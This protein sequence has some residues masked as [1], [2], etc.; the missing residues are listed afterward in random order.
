MLQF[1]SNNWLLSALVR[2]SM[3]DTILMFLTQRCLIRRAGVQ[4]LWLC[5]AAREFSKA[6]WRHM[7]VRRCLAGKLFVRLT[8]A[9]WWKFYHSRRPSLAANCYKRRIVHWWSPPLWPIP[10]ARQIP[11]SSIDIS[12]PIWWL[13]RSR[14]SKAPRRRLTQRQIPFSME[15]KSHKSTENPSQTSENRKKE[16]E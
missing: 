9:L 13:V 1:A 5:M 2:L 14:W 12:V 15:F 7:T 4:S 10:M 16:L 3:V 8:E 11:G 6:V